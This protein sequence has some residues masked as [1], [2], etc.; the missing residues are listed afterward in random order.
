MNS[1]LVADRLRLAGILAGHG[2]TGLRARAGLP[3]RALAWVGS[4]SPERLLIAPQDIRPGN[5]VDS[6]N[7]V[8]ASLENVALGDVSEAARRS[9]LQR[10]LARAMAVW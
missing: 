5:Q 6:Q 9:W 7:V 3:L 4:R 1:S 8:N 10:V 2:L